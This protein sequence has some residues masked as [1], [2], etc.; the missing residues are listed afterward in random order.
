MMLVPVATQAD[1]G[2]LE[3]LNWEQDTCCPQSLPLGLR[4]NKFP[5]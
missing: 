3:P 4:T 2:M 1:D 5:T